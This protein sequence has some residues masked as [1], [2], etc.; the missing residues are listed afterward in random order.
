MLC[1]NVSR[2]GPDY[3]YVLTKIK[4]DNRYTFNKHKSIEK[5]FYKWIS[6]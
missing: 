2:S 5:M 3:M 4:E 6:K 1:S